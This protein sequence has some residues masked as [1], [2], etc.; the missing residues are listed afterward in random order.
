MGP[1]KTDACPSSKALAWPGLRRAAAAGREAGAEEALTGPSS[2][3]N[4]NVLGLVQVVMTLLAAARASKSD[5]STNADD[6]LSAWRGRATAGRVRVSAR[7]MVVKGRSML[8]D[9]KS[10]DKEEGKK[11]AA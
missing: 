5:R 8:V 2:N 11:R 7:R 4:A 3:V 10:G 6:S 9:G 1:R